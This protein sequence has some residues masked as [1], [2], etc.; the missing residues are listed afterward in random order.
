[1]GHG[2]HSNV[3]HY[4]RVAVARPVPLSI[5]SNWTAQDLHPTEVSQQPYCNHHI[6]GIVVPTDFHIFQGVETT[7]QNKLYQIIHS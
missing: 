1:M 3:S 2:F 7:N 6:L 4:Q 5:L